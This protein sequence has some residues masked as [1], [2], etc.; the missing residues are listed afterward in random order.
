MPSCTTLHP[1]DVAPISLACSSADAINQ[2]AA[3]RAAIAP[4]TT[5]QAERRRPAAAST[6][7]K[8]AAAELP[9][10]A[11]EEAELAEERVLAAEAGLATM[12]A[13]T[14]TR[15][16]SR[17]MRGTRMQAALAAE[18]E[19]VEEAAPLRPLPQRASALRSPAGQRRQR[20]CLL[21]QLAVAAQQV[22]AA[23]G[24]EEGS[25]SGAAPVSPGK[26]VKVFKWHMGGCLLKQMDAEAHRRALVLALFSM[27]TH[28]VLSP[29]ARTPGSTE[30]RFHPPA[31]PALPIPFLFTPA[32]PLLGPPCCEC[33]RASAASGGSAGSW[34]ARPHQ[35][36]RAHSLTGPPPQRAHG[37]A[38][39][40]GRQR[41]AGASEVRPCWRRHHRPAVHC[42]PGGGHAAPRRPPQV[43][44]AVQQRLA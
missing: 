19:G 32:R 39:R 12:A 8:A 13:T 37:Q 42:M 43:Q 36:Q 17:P 24:E 14:A 7:R 21:E 44:A 26:W 2:H 1:I 35:E 38:L 15:R 40:C 29:N 41:A 9:E 31:H 6:K 30:S 3:A 33:C 11:E 18:L 22:E 25:E 27:L 5:V 10:L 16:S 28:S 23:A 4:P 20:A 34:A